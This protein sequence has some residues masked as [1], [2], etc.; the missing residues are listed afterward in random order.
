[1]SIVQS[2]DRMQER[3]KKGFL[4]RVQ[5]RL[6]LIN[7]QLGAEGGTQYLSSQFIKLLKYR[8]VLASL[9]EFLYHPSRI[10]AYM[11]KWFRA[12]SKPIFTIV[13]Q[14]FWNLLLSSL[15]LLV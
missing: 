10:I 8:L 3:L 2:K 12:I 11:R 4:V 6:Q 9:N 14:L 7:W 1:M 5:K 13:K 15:L